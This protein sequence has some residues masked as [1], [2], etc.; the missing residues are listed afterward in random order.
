MKAEEAKEL[1]AKANQI[2]ET[3]KKEL[4]AVYGAIKKAALNGL[5]A[6]HHHR[7]YLTGNGYDSKYIESMLVANLTNNGYK[8]ERKYSNPNNPWLLISWL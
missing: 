6:Y 7:G 1:S 2:Q 3:L 5:V 4:E 8:V